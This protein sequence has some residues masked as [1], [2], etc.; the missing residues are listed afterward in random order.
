MGQ[1]RY[2]YIFAIPMLERLYFG[3]V[4]LVNVSLNALRLIP[5]INMEK[6][7]LIG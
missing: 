7:T 2:I 5:T 4:N 6:I 1:R 3:S